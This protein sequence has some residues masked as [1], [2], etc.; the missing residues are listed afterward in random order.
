[1]SG[2]DIIILAAGE[3]TRMKSATPKVLHPVGGMPMLGHVLN[4]GRAFGASRMAVVIGPNAP[5][6]TAYLERQP[7]AVDTYV[8]TERLGTGHA[9]QAA[10]KFYA[11]VNHC[12]IVLFGDT[13]LIRPQTLDRIKA[14]LEGNAD[15]VVLGFEP[16]N[17]TGYGRLLTEQGELIAIREEKDA[18]ETERKIS[19]CNAGAMG[20]APGV[21]DKLLASLTN[22]NAQN[23]YYLTD[24]VELARAQGLSVQIVKGD[25]VDAAGVNSRAQ[26]AD[27]E[28]MFQDRMRRQAMENG[29]TL[30]AP[31]TIYF[32]HDT[33]IEPDVTLEP[34][35][36]FGPKVQIM[37]G[38]TIKAF[39]H[40]EG[41]VIGE[42]A[43]VGPF[44]RLR[45]GTDL[46]P[47][48]KVGN[49]VEVKAAIVGKGSKINHLSYI[50][51]ARIGAS[52]NI[53][54]GAV[55]CNYDG[56]LKHTTTL[57]DGSFIGSGSLLVA[58]VEI[59]AN[60]Y[61]ATGSV[62]TQDVPAD[63]L[64]FG[65]AR[66]TNKDGRGA[67]LKENLRAAKAEASKRK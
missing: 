6:V 34:N 39:S 17:P 44:A 15:L 11:D 38:A 29:V 18:S 1:M 41:A 27:V 66:Q 2:V 7:S 3:G 52:V 63:A 21:L 43:I 67:S 58:P 5:Q 19:L 10:D 46:G 16:Q 26:L 36:V 4:S 33:E 56:F 22:Q 51:D 13:P 28:A 20:F 25:V 47:D 9:V 42:N 61:V 40:I 12:N 53:G 55:T 8:Q 14:L 64:A 59:G 31:D 60:A 48:T 35:V 37:R 24:C 65:R 49:F 32:A 45:P 57:G 23:E 50:G 62:I 54:A 30:T